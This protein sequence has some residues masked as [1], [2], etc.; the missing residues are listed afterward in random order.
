LSGAR[1]G[2]LLLMPRETPK[3]EKQYLKETRLLAFRHWD[4]KSSRRI[5]G[6][7]VKGMLKFFLK[8]KLCF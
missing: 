8:K 7:V 3:G 2:L 5:I 1:F 6:E 4:M